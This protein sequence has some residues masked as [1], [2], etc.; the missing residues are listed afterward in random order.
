MIN[1]DTSK[2]FKE[3]WVILEPYLKTK[4]LPPKDKAHI[5]L[6][7]LTSCLE[8]GCGTRAREMLDL[9]TEWIW[10]W[11]EKDYEE[12]RADNQELKS[13]LPRRFLYDGIYHIHYGRYMFSSV[14]IGLW[15][16]YAVIV[17]LC[18]VAWVSGMPPLAY[19]L[20]RGMIY[21]MLGL[22]FLYMLEGYIYENN[23]YY[24]KMLDEKY[25]KQY[26]GKVPPRVLLKYVGYGDRTFCEEEFESSPMRMGAMY[27]L[28]VLGCTDFMDEQFMQYYF[29]RVSATLE[30]DCILNE[31]VLD[32]VGQ[33]FFLYDTLICHENKSVVS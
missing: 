19:N 30:R 33:I 32:M 28:C 21:S 31:P 5:A 16:L 17:I 23:E 4:N 8:P 7:W 12:V 29:H 26:S 18:F 27:M 24:H 9:Y 2:D 6:Y 14:S 15:L 22:I 11:D 25:S 10:T 13:M 20:I 3:N 1:L